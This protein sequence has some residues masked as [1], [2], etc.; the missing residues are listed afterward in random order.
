M[1]TTG[2]FGFESGRAGRFARRLIVAMGVALIVTLGAWA[3][4]AAQQ[5]DDDQDV[6]LRLHRAEEQVRQLTGMVEQLQFRNRQLEQQLQQARGASPAAPTAAG[7]AP[8]G[9]VTQGQVTQGQVAQGQVAPA[10]SLPPRAPDGQNP[11]QP[12][13]QPQ[14]QP[15]AQSSSQASSQSLPPAGPAPQT[16]R[17]RGDVFDPAANPN[18]PG[19]PRALGTNDPDVGA[20]GGRAAGEPLDLSRPGSAVVQQQVAPQGNPPPR[21]SGNAA[22]ISTAPPTQSPRDMFDLGYGYVLRKDYALAEE[23][24]QAFMQ[25]YASDPL[26]ADAQYWLGEARFQRQNYPDA[27]KAFIGVTTSH[28]TSPRAPEALLRLGQS[29]AAMGEKDA[30]CAALGEVARKYPRASAGVKQG[31]GREQKRINCG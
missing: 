10:S 26:A 9:Q 1:M 28:G 25:K 23:T 12:S 13:Q 27:A 31:V 8:S 2:C 20:P 5:D 17:G 22:A 11:G 16:S 18:A 15:S 14:L 4:L 7:Q 6:S 30:A 24:L 21:A 19:A 29:L 3:P